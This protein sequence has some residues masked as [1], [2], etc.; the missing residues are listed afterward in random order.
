MTSS[1]NI[2]NTY[3]TLLRSLFVYFENTYT[4]LYV[5]LI[6]AAYAKCKIH[7]AYAADAKKVRKYK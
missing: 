1:S 4:T 6:Y 7:M 2:E 3:T 5:T